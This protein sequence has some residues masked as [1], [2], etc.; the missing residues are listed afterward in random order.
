[1][2]TKLTLIDAGKP[3]TGWYAL[4]QTVHSLTPVGGGNGIGCTVCIEHSLYARYQKG[5]GEERIVSR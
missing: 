1:M 2:C 3:S 5:L 4:F